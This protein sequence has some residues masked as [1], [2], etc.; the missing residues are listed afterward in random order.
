MQ[1][2]WDYSKHHLEYVVAYPDHQTFILEQPLLQRPVNKSE[3]EEDDAPEEIPAI[4]MKMLDEHLPTLHVPRTLEEPRVKYLNDFPAIGAYFSTATQ[5]SSGR[6]SSILAADTL[7]PY[8]NGQ[9]LSNTDRD[10]I[11]EIARAVAARLERYPSA[12]IAARFQD[13]KYAS[14]EEIKDSMKALQSSGAPTGEDAEAGPEADAGEGDAEPAEAEA[15]AN[16][17]ADESIEEAEI[18]PDAE[19]GDKLVHFGKL[20]RLCHN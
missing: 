6:Y 14:I 8:G 3:E 18:D 16:D 7:V 17:I 11:W 4:T 5:Q 15:D 2:R 19:P 12:R 1:D 10:L 20:V 13:R 9:P